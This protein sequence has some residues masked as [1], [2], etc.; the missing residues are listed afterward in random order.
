MYP[1]RRPPATQKCEIMDECGQ[2]MGEFGAAEYERERERGSMYSHAYI[3]QV[4]R[5]RAVSGELHIPQYVY[6]QLPS[7]H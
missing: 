2:G 4:R 7:W 5:R 6:H 3:H 1:K